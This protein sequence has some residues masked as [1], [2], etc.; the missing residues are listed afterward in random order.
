MP[1]HIATSLYIAAC[2]DLIGDQL[3]DGLG[4]VGYTGFSGVLQIGE[5]HDFNINE[6][7]RYLGQGTLHGHRAATARSGEHQHRGHQVA[8][9]GDGADVVAKRV[10]G[11]DY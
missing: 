7:A 6:I 11:P 2:V 5:V 9:I 10:V 8:G 1:R 4:F 3:C